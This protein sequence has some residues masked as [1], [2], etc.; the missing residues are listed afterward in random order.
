M[1][2]CHKFNH[3]AW[4][5][6]LSFLPYLS[7]CRFS[8]MLPPF[9]VW[10][11]SLYVLIQTINDKRKLII[12]G[13][14][15]A[16]MGKRLGYWSFWYGMPIVSVSSWVMYYMFA[17]LRV[18]VNYIGTFYSYASIIFLSVSFPLCELFFVHMH[19]SSIVR[20]FGFNY[21]QFFV[22]YCSHFSWIY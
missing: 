19:S 9:S 4:L 11:A 22:R 15:S 17:S 7:F 13:A 3:M 8:I 18:C 16:E 10:C 5:S 2:R 14:S 12:K 20:S 21:L 1:I 6:V